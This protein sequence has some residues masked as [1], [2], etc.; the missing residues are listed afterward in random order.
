MLYTLSFLL[1]GFRLAY[2]VVGIELALIAYSRYWFIRS[3]LAPA[4]FQVI[5]RCNLLFATGL[6]LGKTGGGDS[7][8]GGCRAATENYGE[9]S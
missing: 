1:S 3:S 5:I 9:S 7:L 2:P 8:C 4:T 6:W